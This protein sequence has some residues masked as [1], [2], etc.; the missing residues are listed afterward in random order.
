MDNWDARDSVRASEGERAERRD[1]FG[2]CG[3]GHYA[4]S[5]ASDGVR[6]R[7]ERERLRKR[8]VTALV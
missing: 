4:E 5:A 6:R 8:E 7:T 3:T 1:G 2:G